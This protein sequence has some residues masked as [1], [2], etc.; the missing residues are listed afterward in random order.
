MSRV[1]NFNVD[2]LGSTVSRVVYVQ[3]HQVYITK[4]NQPSIGD[5]STEAT[6]SQ[7]TYDWMK[8]YYYCT[9]TPGESKQIFPRDHK[10]FRKYVSELLLHCLTKAQGAHVLIE[11]HSG[12]FG[13]HSRDEC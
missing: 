10:L 4:L 12:E 1:D 2:R 11:I 8:P 5:T 9:K 13:N 6:M 7:T 3:F